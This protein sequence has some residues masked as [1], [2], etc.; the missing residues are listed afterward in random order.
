M[1]RGMSG[2]GFCLIRAGTLRG[3]DRTSFKYL[4]RVLNTVVCGAHST[5]K[6]FT[7]A[8]CY[9]KVCSH[10]VSLKPE[11]FFSSFFPFSSASGSRVLLLVILFSVVYNE[12]GGGKEE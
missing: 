6:H 10:G 9:N 1:E 12:G 5:N 4:T 7:A 3:T 11:S 2:N 8:F